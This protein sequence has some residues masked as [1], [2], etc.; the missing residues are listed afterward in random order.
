MAEEPKPKAEAKKGESIFKKKWHGVPVPLI[1]VG[2]GL[3]LYLGYRWYENRNASSSSTT[4][5]ST[6]S[7]GDTTGTGSDTGLGGGLGAGN[8]N[9]PTPAQPPTTTSGFGTGPYGNTG[10]VS[11]LVPQ[12]VTP[13]ATQVPAGYIVENVSGGND[14]AA[15]NAVAGAR[16][17]LAR[18]EKSGNKN[19][20]KNA[21]ANLKKAE[22]V[23][24][25]RNNAYLG[26]VAGGAA[27]APP[28]PTSKTTPTGVA[29]QQAPQ[30]QALAV[31]K[32]NL[33]KSQAAEKKNPSA[34]NKAA[35]SAHESQVKAGR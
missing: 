3:V 4:T 15:V 9:Y 7:T 33:A 23:V 30:A 18:A 5:P 28:I 14:Q 19:A 20:I 31:S 26:A 6:T 34:A 8:E 32:A 25:A 16:A 10:V 12:A 22:A 1:A 17:A 24:T 27:L 35:V 2:G 29:A 13:G 11:G 21:T